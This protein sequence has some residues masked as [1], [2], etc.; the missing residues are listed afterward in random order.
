[1]KISSK[2]TRRRLWVGGAVLGLVAIAAALALVPRAG[3]GSAKADG[4]DKAAV[5]L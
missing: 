2:N 3:N 4:K 1:M 5:P